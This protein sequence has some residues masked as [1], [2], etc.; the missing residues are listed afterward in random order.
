MEKAYNRDWIMALDPEVVDIY[1]IQ[2]ANCN[3]LEKNEVVY[4][5]D[6]VGS[7]KTISSGLMAMDYLWNNPGKKVLVISVPSLVGSNKELDGQFLQDWY[8]RLP[9]EHLGLKD[10]IEIVNDVACNIEKKAGEA[11]GL[12][13]VDEAHEFLNKNKRRRAL[14][15]L[16]AEKVVFLTATPMK[17]HQGE[18]ESYC[19]VAEKI[20]DKEKAGEVDRRWIKEK[21]LI[22]EEKRQERTLICNT[23][24]VATPVTRYFKSTI[25]SLCANVAEGEVAK[26][27]KRC[28]AEIWNYVDEEEKIKV[29][30]EQ[31][32]KALET[33][34]ESRFV[35]FVNYIEGQAKI[36]KDYFD[37]SDFEQKYGEVKVISQENKTELE[38]LKG[39]NPP[40]VVIL[41]GKMAEAGVNMPQ[42][43]YVINYHVAP[44]P[45]SLEQRF[46]R[47]DR[48][49][50]KFDKIHLVF[51]VNSGDYGQ[52]TSTQNYYSDICTYLYNF[53]PFLPCRNAI[54]ST[55]ILLDLE[56]RKKEK[57]RWIPLREEGIE[58]ARILI[59]RAGDAIFFKKEINLLPEHILD[60]TDFLPAYEENGEDYC[61]ACIKDSENFKTYEGQFNEKIG[62]MIQ[63]VKY[64]NDRQVYFNRYFEEY[65]M[66]NQLE[67]IF[68]LVLSENRN[69][70]AIFENIIDRMEETDKPTEEMRKILIEHADKL[71]NKIPFMRMCNLYKE[72]LKETHYNSRGNEYTEFDWNPFAIVMNKMGN[73]FF[74]SEDCLGLSDEFMQAYWKNVPLEE[75]KRKEERGSYYSKEKINERIRQY[76]DLFWLKQKQEGYLEVSNWYKLAMLYE[77]RTGIQHYIFKDIHRRKKRKDIP[78]TMFP[79]IT[80]HLCRVKKGDVWGLAFYGVLYGISPDEE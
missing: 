20:L 26:L 59:E 32:E 61:A 3:R 70:G 39:K 64:L 14:E 71:L 51:L 8:L 50:S 45:A 37:A 4:I 46:G 11:Y 29:L 55:E 69:Y 9:F 68:P 54:L 7:G 67:E 22:S 44:S 65:F 33:E 36:I 52:D 34:K 10:R 76:A 23:F 31:I 38:C 25:K 74:Y 24:D 56:R 6:E 49:N 13:I 77:H 60:D 40:R 19:L 79:N 15:N 58:A 17:Q 63:A 41:T 48:L 62:I 18:L 75:E 30:K 53:I 1:P 73:Y 43:N 80:P 5:F 42:Y 47:V 27:P 16:C 78:E 66:K 35:V 2:F 28:P 21:L 12:L 57:E 72:L